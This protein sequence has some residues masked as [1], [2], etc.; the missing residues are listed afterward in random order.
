MNI[1]DVVRLMH[2]VQ[3][4]VYFFLLFACCTL[5]RIKMMISTLSDL[6]HL[7]TYTER[8]RSVIIVSLNQSLIPCG[9]FIIT[10]KDRPANAVNIPPITSIMHDQYLRQRQHHQYDE[11]NE[12]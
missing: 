2:I 7:H 8:E 11:Q 9:L 3:C 10:Y 6:T 12:Q 5:L 4:I 1:L